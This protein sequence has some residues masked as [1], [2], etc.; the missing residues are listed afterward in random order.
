MDG[1]RI[2]I[3]GV[4]QGVGFR[5]FVYN[6]AV[7][8]S[9][10]GFCLNDSEG[11]VIEAYGD[12]LDR[13]VEE[14]KS[15]APP[16]SRITGLRTEPCFLTGDV[17]GF[18]IRESVSFA[19]AFGLISPDFAVCAEC[20]AELFDPNDRRHLYPF[21]NC[22]NCGPRYSIIKDMPY[23]RP[24]TTMAGFMMCPAC[25]AEYH[26]PS[27]RRFHA[28]PNAC[29]ICGPKAW[30]VDGTGKPVSRVNSPA[31]DEA[32]RLLQEGRIIAI[33][34]IGG[35]HLSCDAENDE[36]VKRLRTSK[37]SSL[38]KA[39][40]SNKP[41]AVMSVDVS[42][43]EGFAEVSAEERDLLEERTRPIV[44]LGKKQ[45]GSLSVHVAPGNS[46][47]GVML[48][49]TPLHHILLSG[50]KFN[51][52]VM[53]SGNRAD[54]PI[55][56]S[57]KDAVEKLSG[58]ADFFLLHDRDI[59]MRVDDSIARITGKR[60]SLSRRAR[61]FVPGAID[62]GEDTADILATGPELKNTFCLTKGRFAIMSTHIGDMENAGALE[63]YKE[64]L[65]N[66]R[67][68]FKSNPSIIA[69]DMH[70]G[71]ATSAF[72]SE[73]AASEG[74]PVGRIVEVQHHHAHIAGVMA[75]HGIR[76]KIFG[77][78]FDGTG[79]GTDGTVWGGE[80]FVC[81]RSAFKRVAHLGT[82]GLP[83]AEMAVKEPWRMALSY[84][85]QAYG[86]R[87]IEV[88]KKHFPR[89]ATPEGA[90]I[91]KMLDEDINTPLTSSAGRLF[92]AVASLA[93]IRDRITYE[94]EAAVNLEAAAREYPIE[95]AAPY[96]FEIENNGLRST[97]RITA[98]DLA[99]MIRS[100]VADVSDGKTPSEIAA[101]FHQTLASI[102]TK[103]LIPMAE[104]TGISDVALS[105]GAF[106]NRLLLS[107]SM[108]SLAREGF[109][110]YI[111]EQVPSNDGGV[112]LGQ[113]AVAWELMKGG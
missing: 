49:Y 39:S 34:G 87:S 28:Q 54:E 100:I 105:G 56:T 13:F 4:V 74:I 6:L 44:L 45:T 113:A 29:E 110:V 103:T 60:V 40:Q 59:Y 89:F 68:S 32:V 20:L 61:G 53:T 46:A 42:A 95:R 38:T 50:A 10:R 58:M 18:S 62:L 80:F 84:L 12:R 11:V 73:Y 31:I 1:I 22:T 55:V 21:I 70:P 86:E 82:T 3:T 16:L 35:F 97:E 26:D 23:D 111:N 94:A 14:L 107:L 98:I 102:I 67:S 30:L 41:F 57:N 72:A 17:T 5:P 85:R 101:K 76:K 81:D 33:K 65:R 2:H 96:P 77:V 78:A 99:Q 9:I 79:Y 109:K 66:L 25:D 71:Y 91:M 27:D 88:I 51:A 15:N 19:G 36:A 8:H 64:S 75:E 24:N 52:L 7:S 108:D 43:V 92:D 69:R 37:R 47:Y 63:F 93:G 83:G 104:A 90:V 106:Q 112:A 48:P